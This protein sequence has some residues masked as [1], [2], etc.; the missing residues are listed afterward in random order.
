MNG[1]TFGCFFLTQCPF[2]KFDLKIRQK[3]RVRVFKV[4]SWENV[5][6]LRWFKSKQRPGGNRLPL[7][8]SLFEVIENMDLI[9]V[10]SSFRFLLAVCDFFRKYFRFMKRYTN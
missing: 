2:L 1:H 4:S 6:F 3:T 5:Y 7:S 9:K 8:L 10:F